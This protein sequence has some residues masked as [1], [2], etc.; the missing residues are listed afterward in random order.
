MSGDLNFELPFGEDHR[1]LNRGGPWA[2]LLGSWSAYV[3]FSAQSGTPLTARVLSNA[4]DVAR[5]TNGTLRAQL[6]GAP[7]AIEHPTADRFFNTS[8]FAMPAPG[9][10]GNSSRNA[11]VR[12]QQSQS[13]PAD[14]QRNPRRRDAHDHHALSCLEHI[15]PGE[16]RGGGH[17]GEF[18][19]LRSGDVCALDAVDTNQCEVE[20]L[21]RLISVI[22]CVV[23]VGSP[24]FAQQPQVPSTLFRTSRD[25]VSIDVV[26]R[27]R[28]GAVVRGLSA[29]RLRDP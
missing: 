9:T 1:W 2:A 21:M 11:I 16:L 25:L 26:V 3:T 20:I 27:D 10:F 8:A 23:V 24:I 28:T 5:G 22:V 6:T 18:A 14:D 13:R 12:P 19:H 17:G 4:S 7:I 15:Q 29:V